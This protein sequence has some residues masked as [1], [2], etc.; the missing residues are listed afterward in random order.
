[1]GRQRKAK[2]EIKPIRT[3]LCSYCESGLV[4]NESSAEVATLSYRR[5]SRQP[6]QAIKNL[7]KRKLN[8][9]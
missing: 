8:G 4:F 9:A 7:A 1:M 3:I 6:G 5:A 2:R